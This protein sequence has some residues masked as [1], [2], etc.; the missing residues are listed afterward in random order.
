[1]E[2]GL[3]F[4][5]TSTCR[6]NPDIEYLDETSDYKLKIVSKVKGIPFEKLKEQSLHNLK[7]ISYLS[8][9]EQGRVYAAGY[10]RDMLLE[11]K[12]IAPEKW[13]NEYRKKAITSAL[14]KITR[15]YGTY[16]DGLGHKLVFSVSTEMENKIES[17]GLDLDRI[18]AKEVKKVMYEFQRKFHSG[19]KIGYAWGIHHDSGHRHIHIY[20]SNRTDNGNYVAMSN[21][22]KNRRGKYIQKDQIG[23]I[24][25]RL[26]LA[27]KRMLKQASEMSQ[28]Q[29]PTNQEMLKIDSFPTVEVDS[30]LKEREEKLREHRNRLIRK[31]NELKL[32]KELIRRYYASY[33]LRQ[34]LI[35]QGYTD[36]KKVNKMMSGEFEKL[37]N[38]NSVFPIK[39]LSKLGFLSKSPS[40]KIYSRVLGN[41]QRSLSQIQREKVFQNINAG[42]EFKEQLL[43]QLDLL[44]TEKD[45]YITKTKELKAQKRAIENDLYQNKIQYRRDLEAYNFDFCMRQVSDMNLRDKYIETTKS[46]IR[47]RKLKADTS[48]ELEYLREAD[49]LARSSSSIDKFLRTRDVIVEKGR[50]QKVKGI[51]R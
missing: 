50:V 28:E 43:H 25:E 38:I 23:Y 24:K 36:I 22:L 37:K 33:Y 1:M 49:L 35:K 34:D 26:K 17:S 42:K 27:Q 14:F 21:P 3:L 6:K 47:K 39:L 29:K 5:K 46:L 18:L 16:R 41:L 13:N 7:N 31:E 12:G 8:K 32:Q 9:E 51:S 20:L 4:K 48:E 15:Q 11:K 30:D 45:F 19:E 44:K 2:H 40:I 10:L